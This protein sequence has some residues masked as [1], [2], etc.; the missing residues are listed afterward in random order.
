LKTWYY[1]EL[2]GF[3]MLT[4][5]TAKANDTIYDYLTHMY[6][7]Q[8]AQDGSQ[9]TEMRHT[10]HGHRLSSNLEGMIVLAKIGDE[11][12]VDIWHR[13]TDQGATIL[14]A[15]Q[16]LLSQNLGA[17][18]EVWHLAAA[19]RAKYG[20]DVFLNT[21]VTVSASNR[22]QGLQSLSNDHPPIEALKAWPSDKKLAN[23]SGINIRQHIS[24]IGN[25]RGIG[26]KPHRGDAISLPMACFQNILIGLIT[27]CSMIA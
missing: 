5:D 12:G 27:V 22:N 10:V 20:N 16:F 21:R 25:N 13:P 9:P 3:Y 6:P 15:V 1:A 8:I 17:G 24:N 11:V 4:E 14:T 18:S 23:P 2:A 19:V 7:Q 26:P